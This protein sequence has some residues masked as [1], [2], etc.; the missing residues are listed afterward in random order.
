MSNALSMKLK[1]NSL[2]HQLS[3]T[4][5]TELTLGKKKQDWTVLVGLVLVPGALLLL[6]FVLN[7]MGIGFFATDDLFF[8]IAMS[9]G[10]LCLGG[11]VM[12]WKVSKSKS[13]RTTFSRNQITIGKKDDLTILTNADLAKFVVAF[14]ISDLDQGPSCFGSLSTT[15]NYGNS[16]QLIHIVAETEK[17]LIS[18]L[19][20]IQKFIVELVGFE[21]P[22]TTLETSNP[23]AIY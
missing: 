15:D 2:P 11:L 10:G 23:A 3:G 7:L 18:D 4:P 14:D 21:G 12:L 20:Y 17:M 19:H 6:V 16:F 5:P 1:R 13:E 8:E 9:L 22:T